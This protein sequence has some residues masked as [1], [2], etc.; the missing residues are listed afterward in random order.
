M[1]GYGYNMMGGVQG[2]SILGLF[3]WLVLF[4]DL[5]LVGFWL[6]KHIQK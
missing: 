2:G 4:I 5:V 6:W 3:L 1:W